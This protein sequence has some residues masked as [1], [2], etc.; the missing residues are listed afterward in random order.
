MSGSCPGAAFLGLGIRAVKPRR[1]SLYSLERSCFFHYSQDLIKF[2]LMEESNTPGMG[3]GR[4]T[5]GFQERKHHE[6]GPFPTHPALP[7]QAASL[8]QLKSWPFVFP[9]FRVWNFSPW[10]EADLAVKC[11]HCSAGASVSVVHVGRQH[12]PLESGERHRVRVGRV[13]RR[14]CW[15]E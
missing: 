6:D 12:L 5:T 11:L 7:V 14:W 4:D 13:A 9:V 3:N 8:F 15:G 10:V 1:Y 2:Y